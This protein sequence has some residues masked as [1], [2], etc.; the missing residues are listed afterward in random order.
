ML[1]GGKKGQISLPLRND[2]CL[3][4]HKCHHWVSE[5]RNTPQSCLSE[6]PLYLSACFLLTYIPEYFCYIFY[7][8][9]FPHGSIINTF[10]FLLN[11]LFPV[12]LIHTN[13][14]FTAQFFLLSSWLQSSFYRHLKIIST[15][16][17]IIFPTKC[18]HFSIFPFSKSYTT[19]YLTAQFKTRVILEPSHSFLTFPPLVLSLLSLSP[20]DQMLIIFIHINIIISDIL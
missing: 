18:A 14:L 17:H 10:Y 20:H 13:L 16:E 4:V 15:S 19:P 8:S 12:H 11:T 9:V 3:K 7:I 5:M 1:E 6:L 2:K